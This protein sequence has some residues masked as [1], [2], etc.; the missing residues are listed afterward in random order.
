MP[1]EGFYVTCHQGGQCSKR[2]WA[3]KAVGIAKQAPTEHLAPNYSLH[4]PKAIATR[5]STAGGCPLGVLHQ[6]EQHARLDIR[7][8]QTRP[9]KDQLGIHAR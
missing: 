2:A 5:A 7:G 3:E 6:H 4:P 9:V 1:V 8:P